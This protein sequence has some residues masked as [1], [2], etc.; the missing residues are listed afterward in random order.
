MGDR[1]QFALQVGLGF[2]SILILPGW[3]PEVSLAQ[4]IRVEESQPSRPANLQPLKDPFE[5]Q[6]TNNRQLSLPTG[7]G[8]KPPQDPYGTT[9]L[10][11]GGV[12]ALPSLDRTAPKDPYNTSIEQPGRVIVTPVT[13]PPANGTTDPYGTAAS[14]P[15]GPV[16]PEAALPKPQTTRTE[17]LFNLDLLRQQQQQRR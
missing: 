15:N 3:Q 17:P 16:R 5:T 6:P 9:V 2:V 1:S 10:T 11:P 7:P 8:A 13:T 4:G 12:L 14:S